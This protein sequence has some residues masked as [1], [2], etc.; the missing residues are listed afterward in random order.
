MPRARALRNTLHQGQIRVC[1]LMHDQ[2]HCEVIEYDRYLSYQPTHSGP[3]V[4]E[5]AKNVPYVQLT[6]VQ[7]QSHLFVLSLWQPGMEEYVPVLASTGDRTPGG[8][9]V[10]VTCGTSTKRG[11]PTLSKSCRDLT[12]L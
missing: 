11:N 6:E 7:I 5:Q 9:R 12:A 10:P 3:E 1:P 8:G 2:H 4:A